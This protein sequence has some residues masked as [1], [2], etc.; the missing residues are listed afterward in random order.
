MRNGMCC[1]MLQ[2]GLHWRRS[3]EGKVQEDSEGVQFEIVSKC[4]LFVSLATTFLTI[5]SN[6]A[7]YVLLPD[8]SLCPWSI[9]LLLARILRWWMREYYKSSC[10]TLYDLLFQAT[11]AW[12]AKCFCALRTSPRNPRRRSTFKPPDSPLRKSWLI[13]PLT[14]CCTALKKPLLY[15]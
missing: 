15:L 14:D 1:K 8:G 10:C 5:V 12:H 4:R 11:D 6:V 13:S 3:L 9:P 7:L 2:S